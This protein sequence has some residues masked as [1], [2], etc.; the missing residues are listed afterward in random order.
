MRRLLEFGVLAIIGLTAL[1]IGAINAPAELRQRFP[2]PLVYGGLA[3]LVLAGAAR[4]T[5]VR[6]TRSARYGV[7]ALL[8]A[9]LV[10]LMLTQWQRQTAAWRTDQRREIMKTASK[11]AAADAMQ[12]DIARSIAESYTTDEDADPAAK[13]QSEEF[14]RGLK[15][16]D[17]DLRT[18]WTPEGIESRLRRET[19][20]WKW[21]NNRKLK[22]GT[23]T[24]PWP[25]L[26]T[27]GELLL[28]VLLGTWAF[29]SVSPPDEPT[30]AIADAPPASTDISR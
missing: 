8:L 20:L 17:E 28:A 1:V 29:R 27:L 24:E 25:A 5:G 6:S 9:A 23:W 10:G 26:F 3:G 11:S 16:T 4:M 13:K 12:A 22:Q 19:T 21:L 14:V 30:T 2:V 15:D 7:A 18:R